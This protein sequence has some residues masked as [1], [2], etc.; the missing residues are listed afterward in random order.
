MRG[1]IFFPKPRDRNHVLKNAFGNKNVCPVPKSL[2]R[3]LIGS[4]FC[5]PFQPAS[6]TISRGSLSLCCIK[7]WSSS[8]QAALAFGPL[9]MLDKWPWCAHITETLHAREGWCFR[10]ISRDT[11]PTHIEWQGRLDW[12]AQVP[13]NLVFLMAMGLLTSFSC[14][15]K[16]LYLF[17]WCSS[18]NIL[19]YFSFQFVSWKSQSIFLLCVIGAGITLCVIIAEHLWLSCRILR[20]TCYRAGTVSS[21]I[22]PNRVVIQ[23]RK[24]KVAWLSC[25]PFPSLVT[26]QVQDKWDIVALME[27]SGSK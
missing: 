27:W 20:M 24:P 23:T 7:Q 3:L 15:G 22:A 17:V 16:C 6:S 5:H 9:E 18:I 10:V 26:H 14:D 13:A 19:Q 8:H 1:G 2:H 12:L 4:Q 11:E 25:N 21:G